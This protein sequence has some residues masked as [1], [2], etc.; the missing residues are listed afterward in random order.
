LLF[1]A[2]PM[3]RAENVEIGVE[4]GVMEADAQHANAAWGVRGGVAVGSSL[5]LQARYL[6]MNVNDTTSLQELGG[7][8]R[9]S[10]LPLALT[11]YGFVG[12]ARRWMTDQAAWFVP[13]GGGL[14]LPLAP[15]LCLAPELTWHH[16]ISTPQVVAPSLSHDGWNISVVLHFDI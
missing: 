9:V 1:F 5:R 14:D 15:M 16:L 8:L 11:P 12:I 4:G 6:T 13:F 10:L 3:A 7:Q 2:T